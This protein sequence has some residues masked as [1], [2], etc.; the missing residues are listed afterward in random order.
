M[1]EIV[2][3]DV[4]AVL[5][6][7]DLSDHVR[8]L[9]LSLNVEPQ[10]FTAMGNTT[11]VRK[12]GLKDW[13]VSIEFNQDYASGSVDATLHA[14]WGGELTFVGKPTSGAVS[15]TNPSFSGTALLESFTSV[16]GSVGDPNTTP[17]SL[18]AAGDLT[19]A[20]S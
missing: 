16:S 18:S 4:S 9:T 12:A 15:T 14:N 5:G 2:L 20:T 11:R 7:V 3:T 8:S 19:R 10:D 1:A 17:V 6:G 13:S